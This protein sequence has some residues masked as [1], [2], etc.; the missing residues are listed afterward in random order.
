MRIFQVTT[1][2]QA[3][4]LEVLIGADC[5]RHT[6]TIGLQAPT[7]NTGTILFGD[8]KLQ[9]FELRPLA[10]ANLPVTSFKEVFVRSAT[11]Q[12]LSIALFDG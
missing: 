11:Q 7:A 5:P 9:P 10:N 1:T 4:S 8:N 3:Q 12:L 6:C 2:A